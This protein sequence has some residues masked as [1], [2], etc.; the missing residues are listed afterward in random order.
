[1][2]QLKRDYLQKVLAENADEIVDRAKF[3]LNIR[4]KNTK[5]KT[6][7]NSLKSVVKVN[8]RSIEISFD[9]VK[10]AGVVDKGRRKGTMPP[11]SAIRKWID[12]KPL[13]LRVVKKKPKESGKLSSVGQK[14]KGVKR[15]MK[16][17]SG[18]APVKMKRAGQFI[19]SS[20]RNKDKAAYAIAMN[21]KENGIKGSN[22]FTDAVNDRLKYLENDV[23]EAFALDVESYVDVFFLRAQNRA[24]KE[25]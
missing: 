4:K 24:I 23:L 1:M 9:A 2:E 21:I 3:Y 18:K 11:V 6:L 14:S 8:P 19:K 20:A 5:K 7:Y 15:L 25:K 16:G 17:S 12:N 10:Y 22:F 13:R